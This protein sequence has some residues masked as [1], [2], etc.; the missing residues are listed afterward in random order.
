MSMRVATFALSNQMISSAMTTMAKEAEAQEQESTGVVSTDY[1]GY[2]ATSKR[3]LD[4]QVLVSRSQSYSDAATS[5]ESRAEVMYSSIGSMS[6][7][8]TELRSLLTSATDSATTDSDTIVV[9]A[10][11]YM[12]EFASLLNT[13]Y[14]GRYVFGGSNTTE[15][16]V[17]LSL[18]GA[19][20]YTS[21]ADTS[22]YVGDDEIASVRVSDTQTIS[23]G[24]NANESGFEQAL[25]AFN[26]VANSTD[27]DTDTINAALQLT[28][29]SLDGVTAAQTKVSLAASAMTRA[30][31]YQAEYQD[32][33][34]SLTTDLS[35]V[36]VTAVTVKLSAL[37][38][39]L[40]ASY[41]AISKIM[42]LNLTDYLS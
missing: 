4:L 30:I 31:D 17:D 36:D 29:D 35:G 32:N 6:D 9:Q 37:E 18:L 15:A 28:E 33:A 38:A 26:M 12:E 7:L 34:S 1:A 14:D 41:S 11:E 2:G 22:Y 39:Q 10:Q 24:V 19:A 20:T 23:Y 21:S 5:A 42:S 8:I 40:Q 3:I 13:Q 16:P 27:L 25:R